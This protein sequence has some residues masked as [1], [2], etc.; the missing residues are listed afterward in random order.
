M[1][2]I[3]TAKRAEGEKAYLKSDLEFFGVPVPALRTCIKNELKRP[4]ELDRGAVLDLSQQLWENPVHELRRAAVEVLLININL[5]EKQ[6]LDLIE[7]LLRES[8]TWALV[9]ELAV[10]VAGPI[11]DC[12]PELEVELNRW[13]NDDDFWIRR[14]ALLVHLLPLR[15]GR[16]DFERFARY[17]DSML[18]EKQFFIRKAI[19]W[20]LRETAK[21]RPEMV[22]D[23]LMPRLDRASG[24]TVREAIKRLP[25][26]FRQQ[27]LDTR[28][29]AK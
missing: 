15:E 19:G 29:R 12:F 25:E 26:H 3:G 27:L 16:G 10:R 23:W 7:A 17:A 20:V 2:E 18:D 1:K 8:R 22:V 28:E 6:D 21:K 4:P 24:L 5:L 11:I 9:D 13:S 14:S